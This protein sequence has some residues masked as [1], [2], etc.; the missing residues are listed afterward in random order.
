MAINVIYND[1]HY[2]I[3]PKQREIYDK[4]CKILRW[5]RQHPT[6][7]METFMGLTFSDYQKWVF[8]SSWVPKVCV[9]VMSRSSGK[10][11]TLDTPVYK[12]VN[13]EEKNKKEIVSTTIGELEVG[14]YVLDHNNEFTKVVHLN[15]IVFEEV[16]EI[17][18][19]DGEVIQSNAQ[20]LWYCRKPDDNDWKL[21]ETQDIYYVYGLM[22]KN[23]SREERERIKYLIPS[24]D[25]RAKKVIVEV[26]RTGEKKAMRCITVDN[27]S[28]LF[29]CGENKTVTHNSFLVAP[30]IMARSLL[31]PNH[32]TYIMAPSGSQSQET[33]TKLENLAKGQIA[34]VLGVSSFFLDECVRANAGADPF[35]HSKSGYSVS[36]YNGST[37]NSLNSVAANI[38]GIRSILAL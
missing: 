23:A 38:V 8:L 14:D 37:I 18:F 15:P 10:A 1:F 13:G 9:W 3:L 17:E 5:G 2:E 11:L 22:P 31:F 29:V 20:H 25:E 21:M 27:D 24:F 34:S 35:T 16:F 19:D 6:R 32:N 33:F 12:A 30:F 4:Y 7:F 26:R 28:G 36:L